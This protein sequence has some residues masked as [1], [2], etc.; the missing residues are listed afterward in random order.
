MAKKKKKLSH[1]CQCS[2]SKG[3]ERVEWER[4]GGSKYGYKRETSWPKRKD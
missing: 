1:K 4:G 3:L 2:E